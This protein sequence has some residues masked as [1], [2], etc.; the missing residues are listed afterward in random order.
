MIVLL[1]LEKK[2]YKILDSTPFIQ[3]EDSRNIIQAYVPH[4]DV[5]EGFDIQ[6]AY[7]L[8]NGRT[9]IKLPNSGMEE[10]TETIDDV[11]YN[12]INF[13]LP[14]VA[15]SLSG[16]IVATLIVTT[17]SNDIIKYN[18]LNNVLKSA[19]FEALEE[20]LAD[21]E[22][23]AAIQSMESDVSQLQAQMA[24]KA[25]QATTYTKSEVDALDA[26]LQA[27]ID[28]IEALE[29]LSNIV[30]NYASLQALIALDEATNYKVGAKVQVLSDSTHDNNSTLYNLSSL[31]IDD[32]V[33][34]SYSWEFVGYYDGYNKE[35]IDTIIDNFEQSVNDNFDELSRQVEGTLE[36]QNE[37]IEGLGQ[38][39]PS[40]VDTSTNILAK[41]SDSGIWIGS[42][43]GYWYYWDAVQ[44]KY[45][46]GGVYQTAVNYDELENRLDVLEDVK[47]YPNIYDPSTM[48]QNNI[49]TDSTGEHSA[50]GVASCKVPIIP[51]ETYFLYLPYYNTVF[52]F[53]FRNEN[54]NGN[55]AIYNGLSTFF[56]Q[57]T[58]NEK[59]YIKFVVPAN[60]YWL[61]TTIYTG[62]LDYREVLE[63]YH[64]EK[65]EQINNIYGYSNY[66]YFDKNL[67]DL[68]NKSYLFNLKWCCV[69]DSI[70]EH[71]INGVEYYDTMIANET[72]VNV[73]NMGVA[74]T[75][76]RRTEGD[77]T[78]FYQR[79]NED[80]P[81]DCDIVTIFGSVNDLSFPLGSPSDDSSNLS[82]CGRVKKAIEEVYAKIPNVRL[83]LISPIPQA[84]H[85]PANNDGLM[86]KYVEAQK[87]I[88]YQMGIPYLDLFHS[89]NLRPWD[90]S[91]NDCFYENGNNNTHPITKG[92]KIFY[93]RIRQF[94]E[95]L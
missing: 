91:Q 66:S 41:T 25:N 15:T 72:G 23:L 29:N 50:S 65:P 28:S 42:D 87:E 11:I 59:T 74:G 40:G 20:A 78:C 62:T 5:D 73:F 54:D 53:L 12:V 2:N 64:C 68:I 4:D 52:Y 84:T 33:V 32:G 6:V 79:I 45:V 83:G 69:G 89:S 16:N 21:D 49:Y 19:E 7:V 55:I 24:N 58:Y 60:S 38:L 76:Y 35:Q 30:S 61:K 80:M 17:I 86:A 37:T 44:S 67:T 26:D 3:G 82:I 75:G 39:H 18:V 94:I 22:F 10:T 48:I 95:S 27:Q 1:D 81:S 46:S 77:G 51:N 85:N 36:Q 57:V 88:C 56:E 63:V 9:T 90:S 34:V 70:T 31:V 43:T 92:Y 13:E 8:Q 93:K 71:V 14:R 47:G